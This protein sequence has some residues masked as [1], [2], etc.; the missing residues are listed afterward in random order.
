MGQPLS[1]ELEAMLGYDGLQSDELLLVKRGELVVPLDVFRALVGVAKAADEHWTASDPDIADT[2]E[3]RRLLTRSALHIGTA[4]A[5]LCDAL[6]CGMK[7]S[8][9]ALRLM[10]E[11]SSRLE[12][13]EDTPRGFKEDRCTPEALAKVLDEAQRDPKWGLGNLGDGNVSR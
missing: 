4:R 8:D 9:D 7:D 13:G 11:V 3:S 1:T 12:P 6:G 10:R 5:A 2:P